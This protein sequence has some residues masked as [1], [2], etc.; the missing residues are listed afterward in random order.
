VTFKPQQQLKRS[1]L[2]SQRVGCI[3]ALSLLGH[4]D[5]GRVKN[6]KINQDRLLFPNDPRQAKAVTNL[7]LYLTVDSLFERCLRHNINTKAVGHKIRW[8]VLMKK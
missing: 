3:A 5:L 6:R 4:L 7:L 1:N 8:L 2:L